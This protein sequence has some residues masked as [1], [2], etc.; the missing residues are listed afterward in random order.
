MRHF[1]NLILQM[2][3]RN[4]YFRTILVVSSLIMKDVLTEKT[5]GFELNY[6]M[7]QIL[8]ILER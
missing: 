2:V 3:M 1:K 6:K 7:A 4:L 8:F 5:W